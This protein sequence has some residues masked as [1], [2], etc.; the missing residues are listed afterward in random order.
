MAVKKGYKQTEVG[1]IPED[2]GVKNL[3]ELC[4]FQEGPGLRNWQFTN[5]G[6]KVINVTNLENGVLN[7]ERTDRHISM[8]EFNR[9]YRHFAID[10]SDI[11]MASS[12]NSYSKTAVVRVQDLPLVMNTSVIRFKPSKLCTYGYLWALLR[13]PS[14]KE[15]IDLMIT[16]GAQPN[17]GP[18]HLRRVFFPFPSLTEQESIAGALSDADAWIES[19]EQL[20]AKKRQIKQGSMQELLTGKRRLPGFSGE[21]ETKRFGEIVLLRSE[22]VDPRRSGTFGFCIEL[23]HIEQATGRLVG[24][25]T[26]TATSSLKS[27]F[28]QRDV[29]FGKLRAYLRKY[30]IAEFD[31][32]CSTEIWVM[33]PRTDQLTPEY[34]FQII[35][36]N[37]FIVAA[38]TA[39][40]THMPRSD[41]NVVKNYELRLPSPAEQT[42]I[43]NVL[44][45]MDSE[46]DSLE[47][48]LSKAR[49]IKQGM[50]QELLTGRI[51]LV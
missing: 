51:R 15:Q 22:R 28:K 34:L 13:S 26:T 43:A 5:S 6:M 7:L 27:V 38:S 18:Y 9:M 21:W 50:M 37:H 41:W 29:L 35:T 42:A 2:W 47:S 36:V 48:K 14:F 4:W 44:S 8:S 19:L 1:V 24:S 12:G 49:E 46:I 16:G 3:Q 31:G 39:Y 11:V 10:A 25:T 45:D 17:F 23:E 33:T 32:V 20:I 30:W 40:G